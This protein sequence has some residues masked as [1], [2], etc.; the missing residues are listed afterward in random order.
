[1]ASTA[2]EGSQTGMPGSQPRLATPHNP[3]ATMWMPTNAM[4]PVKRVS[5]SATRSCHAAARASA[6]HRCQSARI[7]R[8][9]TGARLGSASGKLLS[10]AA[11]VECADCER[12]PGTATPCFGSFVEVPER[13]R[14]EWTAAMR[15]HDF[16]RAWT[17]NEHDLS[18]RLADCCPKHEGPRH[19]QHIWQGES[20][21]GAR[22]LVRCYHGLGDTLQF[23]R[24]AAPLRKIAREVIVWVQPELLRL[25]ERVEGVDQALPLHDGAPDV[26][27]DI[28]IEIM[29]LAFALRATRNMIARVP[30]LAP[31]C[32]A[33]RLRRT[34]A[35]IHIGLI[36]RA[37]D[38][39]QRRS[40]NLRLFAPL[41]ETGVHFHLLQP[42][43]NADAPPPFAANDLSCAEIP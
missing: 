4:L 26:D 30:Y 41:A 9:R 10:A 8:S 13:M 27:Y 29:E 1:M 36:W 6:S 28:D 23:I 31:A 24:F 12:V 35:G 40:V 21:A 42:L 33:S 2:N 25:V 39:D 37:G 38:W 20:L 19:L 7:F 5:T 34:A 43:P 15:A 32:G 11:D 14:D 17:L 18:K 16:P 22:V 3:K